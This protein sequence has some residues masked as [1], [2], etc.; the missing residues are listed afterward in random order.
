MKSMQMIIA[1]HLVLSG[2][3]IRPEE[4]GREP[5]LSPV[6]AGLEN[7]R[8]KDAALDNF[9]ASGGARDP[10]KSNL[11]NVS[12][13]PG[14]SLWRESAADLFRDARAM[15]VG[16]VVTVKIQIKDRASLDST[17]NRSRN[18]SINLSGNTKYDLNLPLK[19]GKG[20]GTGSAGLD[21]QTTSKGEGAIARSENIDLMIAAVVT[22]ILPNGNLMINGSQEVRVN[23]EVRVLSVAGI[24][25]PGDISTGNSI[26]YDRIAEA[27][28]SYGGRGRVMEVQQPAYGQQ[29]LDAV[30]PF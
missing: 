12:A 3:S 21:S 4:I 25:R 28:I 30:L 24:V 29:V 17:S 15:K 6:G 1:L 9:Y 19:T 13:R 22:D 27:R 20:E 26:A 14:G 10:V 8:G 11:Q 2:C 5:K 7:T 18:S 23:F 16:D